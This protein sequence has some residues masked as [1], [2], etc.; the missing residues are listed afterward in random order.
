[1]KAVTGLAMD[2]IWR[3]PAPASATK[4]QIGQLVADDYGAL[5]SVRVN[6]E[7][8]A[9]ELILGRQTEETADFTLRIRCCES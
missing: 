6:G 5:Y 1:M 8:K 7:S 9:F 3:N 2:I 4:P